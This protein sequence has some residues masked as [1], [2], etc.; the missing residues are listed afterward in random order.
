MAEQGYRGMAAE[1]GYFAELFDHPSV[2]KMHSLSSREF[3][4]FV[5]YVL[6]RAGY[7][8]KEVGPHFLH[9]VDLEM[10]QIGKNRIVGGVECKKFAPD[11]RVRANV[12]MGVMGAPA[13]TKSGAKPFVVT[14]SDFSDAAH[15]MAGAGAHRAYLI[16]G[17]QLVHYIKYIQG[18]RYDDDHAITW[19]PPEYFAGKD[20]EQPP[21]AD[22]VTILTIANN[23]GGVGKTMTAY[24]LGVELALKGKRVLLI[25]LDGQGNL[26]ERCLQEQLEKPDDDDNH[27]AG[28][29]QYFA[30]ER[31][32]RDLI[33]PTGK[34]GVSLI[35]SDPFLTLRDLGGSGRP[36]IESKFM[37]DVWRLRMQ[38]IAS[39][40]GSPDWI[41]IDTPPAMS[42]F[43]RAALAAADYVLAPIRPRRVSLAGTRNMLL[44]LRTM[45]ALTNTNGR[46]LGTVITHWDNLVISKRFE[47]LDLPR[48]LQGALRE[49]RGQAF[50]AKIPMDNRL[51][52][53]EPGAR[54][55]GAIAY[56]QLANEVLDRV[57][58]R[59]NGLNC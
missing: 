7:E 6:R 12:V 2:E 25:D 46:F 4:R 53:L 45:D 54:T 3:E 31:S 21:P 20:G 37:R 57:E 22:G 34:V 32:L 23:K 27:L 18:S 40:G 1:P 29:V 16:N 9:G 55:A 47:E 43:T 33:V 17:Q 24:Y 35:P 42:A 52:T 50:E 58:Q 13:V 36:D 30:G 8:V 49:F 11:N 39:L 19:I 26:T 14:T 5:A 51:D 38:S 44:T 10:R 59:S 28:V 56:E 48:A 15:Q 41:I